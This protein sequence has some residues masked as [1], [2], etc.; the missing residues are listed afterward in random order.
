MRVAW[1][2]WTEHAARSERELMADLAFW[3]AHH[4][5]VPEACPAC[6]DSM[7]YRLAERSP[8]RCRTCEPVD[9][10]LKVQW[11]AAGGGPVARA[12]AR[13]CDAPGC[14]R[15]ASAWSSDG[16]AWCEAHGREWL[17][18][19]SDRLDSTATPRQPAD[20]GDPRRR[21]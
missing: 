18:K 13:R 8:W 19:E 7:F 4:S 15:P 17:E 3:R 1:Q 6:G 2:G 20:A 16:A 21:L 12:A 9:A 11:L 10:R 5:E 14:R